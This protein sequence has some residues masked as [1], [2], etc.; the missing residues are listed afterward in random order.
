MYSEHADRS[1]KMKCKKCGGEMKRDKKMI[2][3]SSLVGFIGALLF[4]MG[5]ELI[6]AIWLIVGVIWGVAHKKRV[7]KECGH[8]EL[9]K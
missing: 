3:K 4:G 5:D 6:V 7:C 2:L 1:G 9:K 8:S